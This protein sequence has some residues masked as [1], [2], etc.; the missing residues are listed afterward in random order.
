MSSTFGSYFK[1]LR[2]KKGWTLR[3]FCE[4]NGFDPGNISRLERGVFPPPES[5]QKLREYA[6]VLALKE[7]S[8]EWFEFFDRAAA[9]RG[10]LPADLRADEKLLE[11]LPVLFRT[12]RGKKVSAEK[13]DRLAE[14]IRREHSD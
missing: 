14:L 12:L 4:L 6:K 7:G 8:E 13:L 9:S 5:P 3:R 10:Q 11:R 1:A 2:T